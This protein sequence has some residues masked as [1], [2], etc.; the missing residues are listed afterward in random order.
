MEPSSALP[1]AY[2]QAG[3][4]SFV[5]FLREVRPDLLPGSG[6][7][8]RCGRDQ[9]PGR[10]RRSATTASATAAVSSAGSMTAPSASMVT[11]IG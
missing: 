3:T 10:S 9:P 2:F 11:T 1:A 5:D 4:A 6:G 7:V 8:F